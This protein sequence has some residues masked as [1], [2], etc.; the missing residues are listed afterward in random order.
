M[1]KIIKITLVV[2]CILAVGFVTVFL[3][4]KNKPGDPSFSPRATTEN[5][6]TRTTRLDNEARF[7][8]ALSLVYENASKLKADLGDASPLI[9]SP[10]IVNCIKVAESDVS[11]ALGAEGYFEFSYEDIKP[12]EFPI[13]VDNKYKNADELVN[14]LLLTHEITH[15]QQY[16]NELQGKGNLSCIDKE[17]EAFYSQLLFTTEL[18]DEENKSIDFR[19][20]NDRDLHPQL[21]IIS[22]MRTARDMGGKAFGGCLDSEDPECV[23]KYMK[24]MIKDLVSRDEFYIRQCGK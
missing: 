2:V 1:K 11:D 3:L 14:A 16:I 19:I 21:Q 7:D 6:C 20:D 15:V 23:S 10:Q 8:R 4:S 9:F 13:F 12:N 22:A 5:G 24:N 18:N 17:V